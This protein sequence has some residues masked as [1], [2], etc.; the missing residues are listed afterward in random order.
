MPCH[1]LSFDRSCL[2]PGTYRDHRRSEST[3]RGL[4]RD[5]QEMPD[6]YETC[7]LA[8]CS[9]RRDFIPT[10]VP[11]WPP[12][13]V[14]AS[15]H[16]PACAS[17]DR[18]TQCVLD[19]RPDDKSCTELNAIYEPTLAGRPRTSTRRAHVWSGPEARAR[20][21]RA[22]RAADAAA[23]AQVREQF[24]AQHPSGLDEDA[25]IDR[26]GRQ[27]QSLLPR[28]GASKPG[29]DLLMATGRGRA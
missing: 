16:S 27:L 9:H 12:A 2:R 24:P 8:I 15:S 17:P 20:G 7:A 3:A 23:G 1:R 13:R 21:G 10:C 4:S 26:L 25:P 11:V 22:A 6:V 28:I 14:L 19:N 5:T 18:H 29:R